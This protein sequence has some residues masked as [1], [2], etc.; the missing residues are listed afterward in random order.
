MRPIRTT[1]SA[2]DIQNA[3]F[4][5]AAFWKCQCGESNPAA[6]VYCMCGRK[7]TSSDGF[8]QDDS[9]GVN[10]G[11]KKKYVIIIAI[12]IVAVFL[13]VI[14]IYLR[15]NTLTGDDKAAYDMIVEVAHYF[16]N[17]SSVRLASGTVGV[18][19]D[20][21]FCG[22]SATNGFGSRTVSYYFVMDGWI[23]EE[24]DADFLYQDKSKLN[25]EKINKKLEKALKNVY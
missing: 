18:G 9:A 17:P 12:A 24:E 21:L 10:A 7:R 13:A 6:V 4:S 1:T 16:K 2:I 14:L 11:R 5:E 22:I 8:A 20:C 19:R 25:L 23:M 3:S 15:S